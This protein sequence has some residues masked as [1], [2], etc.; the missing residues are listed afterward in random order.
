MIMTAVMALKF[1]Y[2]I[3]DFFTGHGKRVDILYTIKK[4]LGILK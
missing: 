2:D 4:K 3:R 1:R